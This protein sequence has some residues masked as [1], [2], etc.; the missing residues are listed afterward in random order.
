MISQNN[1]INSSPKLE[2]F[3]NIWFFN[4]SD[5]QLFIQKINIK[6][7]LKML[8]KARLREKTLSKK[9]LSNT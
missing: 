7:I 9:Q 2:L 8:L 5:E 4:E 1:K 6:N 3:K